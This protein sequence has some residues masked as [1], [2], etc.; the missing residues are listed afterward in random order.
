MPIGLGGG[1]SLFL[2]APGGDNQA[3]AGEGYAAVRV[4]S[5]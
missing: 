1:C 3:Q 5:E 2:S 4:A